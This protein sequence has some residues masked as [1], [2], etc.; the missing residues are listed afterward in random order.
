MRLSNLALY[1]PQAWQFWRDHPRL[2]LLNEQPVEHQG[3]AALVISF[4]SVT[5]PIQLDVVLAQN[6]YETLSI[7]QSSAVYHIG[8]RAPGEASAHD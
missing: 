2:R 7:Q 1:L 6:T 4:R 8:Q 5:E 3:S